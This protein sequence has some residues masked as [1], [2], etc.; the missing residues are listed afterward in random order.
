MDLAFIQCHLS[1]PS[2]IASLEEAGL[3]LNEALSILDKVQEKIDIIPEDKGNVLQAKL[4]FVLEK[5]PG[6]DTLNN[7]VK[8]LKEQP[9]P[10]PLVWGLEIL[11]SLNTLQLLVLM[12]RGAFLCI[13]I[14]C[15]TG[16]SLSPR[17]PCQR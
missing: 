1:L 4:M 3:P 8:V 12:S 16:D 7:V 17:N 2:S 5:N 15:L 13:K 14:F 10:F 6:L 11:P 9:L